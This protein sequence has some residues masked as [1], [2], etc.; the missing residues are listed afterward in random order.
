[1]Y[2]EDLTAVV[3]GDNT[4]I[5]HS[6]NDSQAGN[7]H[8]F[9][10]SPPSSL[11]ER[12]WGPLVDEIWSDEL[13]TITDIVFGYELLPSLWLECLV[14]QSLNGT[15]STSSQKIAALEASLQG[16]TSVAYSLLVQQ[17]RINGKLTNLDT[18]VQ[19]QQQTP[20]ATLHVNGL[21]TFLG[22]LCVT[23]LFLCVV[24]VARIR[25]GL[26]PQG[27][28]YIIVGD[29]LDLM[30]LIRGSALPELL[31][32][33]KYDSTTPDTRRDKSEKIDVV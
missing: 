2:L 11:Y 19:G 21:Q 14:M 8:P 26:K 7:L 5:S 32:E 12:A 6:F 10:R 4:L 22:L 16:I 27:D 30:C 18:D 1:M 28:R 24:C 29:A 23:S 33:P 25:D 17:L 20:L 9:A 31:A 13:A 3:R 15:S